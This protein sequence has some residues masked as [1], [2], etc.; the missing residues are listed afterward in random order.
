MFPLLLHHPL[1]LL[2]LLA[3]FNFSSH[4]GN[5]EARKGTRE[6][7]IKGKLVCR[8]DIAP[9]GGFEQDSEF[10]TCEGLE[11]TCEIGVA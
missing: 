7:F 1:R 8:R 5:L 9:F 3:R 11:G 4:H 6:P 10:A 2:L